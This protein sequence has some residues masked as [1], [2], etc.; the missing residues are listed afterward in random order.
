MKINI[1]YNKKRFLYGI[2]A[3]LFALIYLFF[4]LF[5]FNFQK[6]HFAALGSSAFAVFALPKMK[7]SRSKNII[8]SYIIAI[9]MGIIFSSFDYIIDIHHRVILQ[10]LFGSLAV[11]FTI[12]TEILFS[13]EHPPSAGVALGL[14]IAPWNIFTILSLMSAI[15]ILAFYRIVTEKSKQYLLKKHTSK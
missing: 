10:S 3:S 4:I 15:L 11:S 12:L 7:S 13:L 5:I 1:N 9:V 2:L 14:L 8:G 6:I